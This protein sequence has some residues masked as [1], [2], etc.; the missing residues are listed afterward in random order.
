MKKNKVIGAL[1]AL[2]FMGINYSQAQYTGL[3][4]SNA[5]YTDC[6]K[7]NNPVFNG[8]YT[9]DINGWDMDA[10]AQHEVPGWYGP[11]AGGYLY[12][13]VNIYM[14]N[15]I[16][17]NMVM[18]SQS[19]TCP[20]SNGIAYNCVDLKANVIYMIRFEAKFH[21]PSNISFCQTK[22]RVDDQ[23]TYN[24]GNNSMVSFVNL[25][26]NNTWNSYEK[27]FQVTSDKDL[28]F[29]QN[30]LAFND[31]ATQC[32]GA[33]SYFK[34]IQILPL[35]FEN[36]Y[37]CPG[38]SRKLCPKC[39]DARTIFNASTQVISYLWTPSYA[40]TNPTLINP[41]VAPNYNTTYQ[42]DLTDIAGNHLYQNVNVIL[43]QSSP[44][45]NLSIS[46]NTTT[47]SGPVILPGMIVDINA[48]VILTVDNPTVF[49][50][51]VFR[52]GAG[53]KIQVAS[54]GNATFNSCHLFSLN[55]GASGWLGVK[56]DAGAH[57]NMTGGTIIENSYEAISAYSSATQIADLSI[58]QTIF[59]NNKTAISF[60]INSLSQPTNNQIINNCI[61]TCRSLPCLVPSVEHFAQ[62]KS[63][64]YNELY[65][66]YPA[67]ANANQGINI[68]QIPSITTPYRVGLAS[69]D[70]YATVNIFDNIAKG[71]SMTDGNSQIQNNLFQN[72]L[73]NSTDNTGIGVCIKGSSNS[74]TIIGNSIT[75][76][77]SLTNE[78]NTFKNCRQ[79]VYVKGTC[80]TYLINN[81]VTNSMI[82]SDFVSSGTNSRG[83]YG[84]FLDV[85]S[86]NSNTNIRIEHNSI[87]NCSVG[88]HINR[89]SMYPKAIGINVDCN[90]IY[91][92]QPQAIT[93]INLVDQSTNYPYIA[94]YAYTVRY[95]TISQMK[96]NAICATS[97]LK[98]LNI[99]KNNELSVK[100]VAGT[101]TIGS[102]LLSSA[103]ALYYCANGRILENMYVKTSLNN[104]NVTNENIVG[105]YLK[106]SKGIAVTNNNITNVGTGVLYHGDCTSAVLPALFRSNTIKKAKYGLYMYQEA[107]IGTQGSNGLPI[108]NLFGTGITTC[109]VYCNSGTNLNITSKLYVSNLTP[110]SGYVY[111]PTT[112]GVG[113]LGLCAY[114]VG[115]GT[116]NGIIP[117]SG[118]NPIY[119]NC[120]T[121][122][123]DVY[124]S[125]GNNAKYNEVNSEASE[126]IELENS[127]DMD[128][129]ETKI[130]PNP[131]NNVFT[132]ECIKEFY[133]EVQIFS[134][135]GN[136]VLSASLNP[137]DNIHQVDVSEFKNGIYFIRIAKIE[138]GFDTF[139]IIVTH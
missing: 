44:I 137:N 94:D 65:A 29:L 38:E 15:G 53:S 84:Y 36:V 78:L 20:W 100:Y 104:I 8:T 113:P 95:N 61:F 32:G 73:G 51:V 90:T 85:S 64:L 27:L 129:M 105:I 35:E 114:T 125:S 81:Q 18:Q 76:L 50:R 92:N 28:L 108:G 96:S 91:A 89:S 23:A 103:I 14:E 111:V 110:P 45:A 9:P 79:A 55:G 116:S 42:L 82:S 136:L 56:V 132:I 130:F 47:S 93:G 98:G 123:C 71:L 66:N 120:L 5:T 62:V 133:S 67:I 30:Q 139:K 131:A 127:L 2:I 77:S 115:T 58:S 117:T 87:F 134:I 107:N 31:G 16:T 25:P 6:N 10:F 13:G 74:S 135:F 101:Q 3:N 121:C 57:L 24:P 1:I 19:G 106:Y 60:A 97:I 59:N 43:N 26:N 128:K 80:Y 68:I 12:D 34:N 54:T 99:Y 124:G 75:N 88:V 119:Q 33:K 72:I 37:L 40:L 109:Q 39:L 48:N 17:P 63:D 138:G 102:G 126:G 7:I 49:E 122:N 112:I 4:C 41:V 69:P 52:M 11:P 22:I 86:D 46:S 118:Y 21:G 70:F 83:E